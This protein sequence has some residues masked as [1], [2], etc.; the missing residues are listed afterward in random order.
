MYEGHSVGVVVPAYNEEGLVGS[1]IETMPS[2]VDRIYVIDD[3]ST[4]G[5]WEEIQE[6]AGRINDLEDETSDG[7]QEERDEYIRERRERTTERPV[8]DGGD[9]EPTQRVVPVRHEH[10]RGAGAAVKTGYSLALADEIDVTA[11]MDGDGQ[12]DPDELDR[13][14][15]PIVSGEAT[16]AKGNRLHSREDRR[17]MSNWRLFGNTL[18]T[19]LTRVASG[20]WEVSDP[21]NGYTAISN[22]GLQKVPFEKLY[23]EYGFLNHLLVALNIRGEPIADVAHPAVYGDE[24]SSIRYSRFVP[25]LSMLLARSFLDRIVQSYLVRR[26]HPVVPCYTL[27]ATV[28]L[29]GAGG[30][31]Y[32]AFASSVDA[33]MGGMVSFL[34]F[35]FGCML[36]VLGCWFDV[37]ENEGLVHRHGYSTLRERREEQ[38]RPGSVPS[39]I[40]FVHRDS[41][42][43]QI[44]P[45]SEDRS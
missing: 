37:K 44:R 6:H 14:I 34:V 22:D 29:V 24:T 18:L 7:A 12:M 10:N 41:T 4:D 35:A 11:V 5:T 8:A 25:G 1:V 28:L 15:D 13:I 36:L 20:Y 42:P 33:F 39:A 23:E 17:E 21:Q 19:M 9:G 40:D 32:A 30:G 43:G 3:A 45:G 26:F 2:F 38:R 27:G 31:L 16:Y